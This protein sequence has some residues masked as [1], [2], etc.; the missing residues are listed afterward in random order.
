MIS[1]LQ[2]AIH[3]KYVTYSKTISNQIIII[4]E[5]YI[6]HLCS[7]LMTVIIFTTLE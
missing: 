2:T 6:E 5:L 1:F 7:L 3:Q 4:N